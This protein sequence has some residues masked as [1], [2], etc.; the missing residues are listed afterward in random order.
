VRFG[1]D[2]VRSMGRTATGVRGIKMPAGEEVVSLI[3]AESAGGSEDE[4]ED[5]NGVEEIA[6]NGDGDR[7]RRRRQR[8]VHPHRHRERLRQAHAA[9]DYPRRAVA[10]GVI[11]IQ[12]TERNGKLVAAGWMGS[13]T[14]SC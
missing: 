4:N 2:K 5:D 14:K 3:V 7:R 9:A 8:A 11:G 1:E 10:Q 13:A 6:A 12:T